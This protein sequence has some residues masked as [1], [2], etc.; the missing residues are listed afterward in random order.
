MNNQVVVKGGE[1]GKWVNSTFVPPGETRTF[2]ENE[3]PVHLRP[4][5]AEVEQVEAVNPLLEILDLSIPAITEMLPGFTDE[6]LDALEKAETD[7]N[8]RVG[9]I[10]AITEER[11][12]RAAKLQEA[13]E[14]LSQ[15][16]EAIVEALDSLNA[17]PEEITYMVGVEQK[18]Q[19]REELLKIMD[20]KIQ[21]AV[22]A[23]A[24]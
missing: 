9:L 16:E 6:E 20:E 14:F 19:N 23:A 5:A 7:G 21:E 12:D 13:N 11:L 10:A 4:V 8:T 2:N 18:N 1:S 22:E 17:T 15:D 24:E 3:V